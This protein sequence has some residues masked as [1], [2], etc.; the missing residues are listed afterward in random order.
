[1]VDFADEISVVI[2]ALRE[3]DLLLEE[4]TAGEVD[5]VADRDGRAF[6]LQR[7]Q[8]QLR[9]TEAAKQAAILNALPACVAVLDMNGHI[10]SVN[11][12]W[13][14]LGAGGALHGPGYHVG[15]SYL[16]QCDIEPGVEALDSHRATAGIRCVLAGTKKNFSMEYRC[17]LPSKRRWA[18]PR[19]WTRRRMQFTSW[20]GRACASFTSTRRLA[21]CR[22]KPAVRCLPRHLRK[23]SAARNCI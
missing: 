18:M 11:E 5:T 16:D 14:R 15:S 22:R 3:A 2:R 8:N 6:L 9:Q 23:S 21:G 17:G 7:A 19:R 1:L 12:L 20:I 10:L 13:M 4:L